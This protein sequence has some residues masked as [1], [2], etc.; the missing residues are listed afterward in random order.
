MKLSTTSSDPTVDT[1]HARASWPLPE[2]ALAYFPD[3]RS[4]H[5]DRDL[6]AGAFTKEVAM[7]QGSHGHLPVLI[8]RCV[9][10]LTPALTRQN[11]DGEGAVFELGAALDRNRANIGV[12]PRRRHRAAA[13][14]PASALL[15]GRRQNRRVVV[16]R[17]RRRCQMGIGAEHDLVDDGAVLALLDA[18][19]M[20]AGRAEIHVWTERI[21]AIVRPAPVVH[22]RVRGS[23]LSPAAS[24]FGSQSEIRFTWKPK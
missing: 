23:I 2:P 4:A 20:D 18:H 1:A 21:P 14:A 13:S 3:A 24:H 12:E 8:D 5:S 9:E 10:L 6:G 7:A 15:V 11:A 19:G 22:A 17:S 16:A